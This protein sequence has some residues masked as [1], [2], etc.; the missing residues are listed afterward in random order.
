MGMYAVQ[1]ADTGDL[2]MMSEAARDSRAV[3]IARRQ[4]LAGG[5]AALPAANDR[6][7]TGF[8]EGRIPAPA[9]PLDAAPA[10]S[11]N[12]HAPPAAAAS[13]GHAL[14]AAFA[15]GQASPS[16]A[17]VAADVPVTQ[18]V[19][20]APVSAGVTDA[21]VGRAM[22]IQRR[23]LQAQ[24]AGALGGASAAARPEAQAAPTAAAAGVTDAHIGRALSI[25]RRRQQALGSGALAPASNAGGAPAPTPEVTTAPATAA[26]V[27]S[28]AHLGR[29]MSIERRRRLSQG[30]AALTGAAPTGAVGLPLAAES[31][32]ADPSSG[33]ERARTRRVEASRYG[34]EALHRPQPE[35]SVSYAPKVVVTP[36]HGG[37]QVTGLRIGQGVRV[38]GDEAG[39][40][41]PVSGTQY[42]SADG[43][44]AV[45]GGGQ[46][47]GLTRT[48]QGLTV[49][50]TAVR[51]RVAIT[52]DEF[53]EHLRIT[54]KADQKLADD[55]T[56]RSDGGYRPA[57][58]P[59]RANPHGA[60]AVGTRPT[61]PTGMPLETT[62]GGLTVSGT[63]VGRGGC[64]TGNEAGSWRTITGNQY[65]ALESTPGTVAASASAHPQG[66]LDPVTASKV[67]VAQTWNGQR[68]TGPSVEHRPNVT[69]DEPGSCRP[70]TGTPYQ[71][72]STAFGWCEPGVGDGSAQR[73][74]PTPRGVA[75]SGD[76]PT[77]SGAVTGTARGHGR[78]V[79]GTAY[80]GDMRAA[81]AVA[82]DWTGSRTF[83]VAL[84]R[85]LADQEGADDV[86]ESG[87]VRLSPSSEPGRITGSFAYGDG[88]VTGNQEF[89]FRARPTRERK[90]SPVTGEGR[91]EGRTITGSSYKANDRVTG[92]EGHFAAGRN[93]SQ[94]GG[95]PHGWAGASKFRDQGTP[96][97]PPRHAVT[98]LS[99]SSP[100]AGSKITLSGG[101]QG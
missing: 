87:D 57:Q 13:N 3:A 64:V 71:G 89:L 14:P 2:A 40:A 98:G 62:T 59:R 4:A 69:G 93:P 45:Q 81:Q 8:R 21:H 24:G 30:K 85:R 76:V 34:S 51:N 80:Y 16:A 67:T 17:P 18:P 35:G 11:S 31:V 61:P 48:A 38:T 29:S 54:G 36:T 63:A 97:G 82:D 52:G 95:E 72:P 91:T 65:A 86:K 75:V 44:P 84:A 25:Q 43:P 12:G 1:T 32:E 39:A 73:L 26:G 94:G 49:S 42:V 20:P 41:L 37:Q 22:S 99:G 6:V 90:E 53:G 7:R 55:L 56:Q 83:P 10:G 27:V 47:V 46:K 9:G 50:G 88:K 78:N 66:R 79:T 19:A 60:G 100:K 92:T 101:A 23:R 68:V 28:D 15:N 74:G 33:R 58:F 70:V 96:A 5:K 77:H